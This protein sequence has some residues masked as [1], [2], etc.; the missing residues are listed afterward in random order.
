MSG[1]AP[2]APSPSQA[3]ALHRGLAQPA[4]AE[5]VRLLALGRTAFKPREVPDGSTSVRTEWFAGSLAR[6]AAV[7]GRAVADRGDADCFV[8]VRELVDDPVGADSK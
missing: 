4:Q 3:R 2:A 7:G 6:V 8:A 5:V 1:R